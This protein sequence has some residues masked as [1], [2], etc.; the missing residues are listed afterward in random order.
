MTNYLRRWGREIAN[1]DG[2]RCH[3]CGADL[4]PYGKSKD[5]DLYFEDVTVM[6]KGKRIGTDRRLKRKFRYA[7][8]DHVK[9]RSKGGAT[10]IDNLVLACWDCN[11]LKAD[12]PAGQ[13]SRLKGQ[14]V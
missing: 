11:Q 5:D 3:Y 7:T 4:V 14:G 12:L 13:L 9:P 2:W 8:V 6:A 1:R 10:R